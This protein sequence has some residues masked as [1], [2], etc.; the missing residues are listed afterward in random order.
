M[1]LPRVLRGGPFVVGSAL[2]LLVLLAMM[3]APSVFTRRDPNAIEFLSRLRPP[4]L[5]HPF[6]PR[7]VELHG[8][9]E[10]CGAL[11]LDDSALRD[12]AIGDDDFLV[13]VDHAA[14]TGYPRL[15]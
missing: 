3:I 8:N 15:P 6:G 13:K 1:R 9:A 4:S 10:S 11:A 14:G 2:V 5:A 7:R 12:V